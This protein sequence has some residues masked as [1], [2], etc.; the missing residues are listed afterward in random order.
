MT[1]T[2]IIDRLIEISQDYTDIIKVSSKKKIVM[3]ELITIW[4]DI[5]KNP[6]SVKNVSEQLT[7]YIIIN[8]SVN[9]GI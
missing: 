9:R 8:S 4:S 6:L 2:I 1:L 5:T 7:L 3:D